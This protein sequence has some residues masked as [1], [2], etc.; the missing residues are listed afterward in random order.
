M[1]CETEVLIKKKKKDFKYVFQ[2]VLINK[3]APSSPR[4]LKKSY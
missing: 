2:F 1:S 4:D 3:C